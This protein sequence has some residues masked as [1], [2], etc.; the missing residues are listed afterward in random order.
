MRAEPAWG[1]KASSRSVAIGLID[2]GARPIGS[3]SKP[4]GTGRDKAD[5]G[6]KL[7]LP[8]KDGGVRLG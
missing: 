6:G 8:A 4:R 3:K 7:A 2:P 5:R 1:S